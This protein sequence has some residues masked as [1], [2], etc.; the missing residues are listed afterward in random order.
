MDLKLKNKISLVCAASEGLGKAAALELAKEGS[1][2]AISS[3]NKEKLELAKNEIS[4]ETG[5]E[6]KIYEADLTSE[7]QIIN[8][9]KQVQT[10]SVS[11]THLTLPTTPYV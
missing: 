6:V 10:D 3:R 9:Y 7:D 5:S 4:S 8:L 11:Y 2:I 1:T